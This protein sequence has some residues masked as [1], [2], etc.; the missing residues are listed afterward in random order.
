MFYELPSVVGKMFRRAFVRCLKYSTFCMAP[1]R[2]RQSEVWHKT[3][4][5]CAIY[6]PGNNCRGGPLHP[7]LLP[8]VYNNKNKKHQDTEFCSKILNKE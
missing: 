2:F 4:S 6:N 5:Y 7:H 1:C 3:F 8:Y